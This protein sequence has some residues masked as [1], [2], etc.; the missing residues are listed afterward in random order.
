M[1]GLTAAAVLGVPRS[2]DGDTIRS[3]FRAR[4]KTTHPDLGGDPRAFAATVDAFNTL[5][6]V[7]LDTADVPAVDATP[8]LAATHGFVAY[9]TPITPRPTRRRSFADELRVAMAR[10]A[11]VAHR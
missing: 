1:D 10:E 4:A 3:A 8:T 5:R 11:A 6:L 2:A 9:D 7:P